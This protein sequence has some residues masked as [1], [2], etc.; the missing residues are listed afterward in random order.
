MLMICHECGMIFDDVEDVLVK[1]ECPICSS[2]DIGNVPNED[3]DME[4]I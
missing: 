3:E 4:S 1:N 2:E